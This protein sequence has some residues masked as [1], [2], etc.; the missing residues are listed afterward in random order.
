MALPQ[1]QQ[2]KLQSLL[3]LAVDN[4]S[5][6]AIAAKT[7][8]Q[9]QLRAANKAAAAKILLSI[10]AS[11]DSSSVSHITHDNARF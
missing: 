6:E 8:K 3:K 2:P 7:A 1:L 11:L 9:E 4:T 10:K 5:P